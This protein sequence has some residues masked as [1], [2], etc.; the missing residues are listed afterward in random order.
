MF[1]HQIAPIIAATTKTKHPAPAAFTPPGALPEPPPGRLCKGP[2]NDAF[3]AAPFQIPEKFQA[4][5]VR[6]PTMSRASV[7][8]YA[9]RLRDTPPGP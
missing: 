9:S 3:T 2:F 8:N 7:L 5:G 1:H 4:P 6:R